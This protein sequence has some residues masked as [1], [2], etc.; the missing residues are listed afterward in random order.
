MHTIRTIVSKDYYYVI[1]YL[2]SRIRFGSQTILVGLW[3]DFIVIIIPSSSSIK[4][5]KKQQK[6][7]LDCG[8]LFPFNS[9]IKL[10]SA[11]DCVYD[12]L[13]FYTSLS[14]NV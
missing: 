3:T 11:R 8:M 4:L 13:P 10:I 5:L 12:T 9:I 1:H 2:N 6:S 14:L 7:F